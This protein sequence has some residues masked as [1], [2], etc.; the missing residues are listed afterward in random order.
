MFLFLLARLRW[1]RLRWV[2]LWS[3]LS[4]CFLYFLQSKLDFI[5]LSKANIASRSSNESE[6]R[7]LT[8]TTIDLLWIWQFWHNTYSFIFT[9]SLW[10]NNLASTYI[11]VNPIFYHEENKWKYIS[12]FLVKKWLT[13]SLVL[14]ISLYWINGWCS[15]KTIIIYYVFHLQ[16]QVHRSSQRFSLRGPTK[17]IKICHQKIL[18]I[19]SKI[20]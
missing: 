1:C 14:D 17:K 20:L 9:T 12:S 19:C 10:Y 6:Y 5:Q 7:S 8:C 16:K 3:S 11:T 18:K 4:R 15:N 13:S 2:F